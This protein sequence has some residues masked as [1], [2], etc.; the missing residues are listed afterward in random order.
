MA[1][2]FAYYASPTD[3]LPPYYQHDHEMQPPPPPS[4][5]IPIDPALTLYPP[6]YSH[7]QPQHHLALP[8]YSSPSSAGSDTLGTPPT[9]H[10]PIFKRPP[11]VVSANDPSTRKKPRKDD[12]HDEPKPKPTRGSR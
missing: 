2:T 7:F 10:I 12:D 9:E 5:S 6:Y 1:G 11:S 3:T 8:N 4:P